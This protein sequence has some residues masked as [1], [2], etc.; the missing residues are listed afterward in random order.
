MFLEDEGIKMY[1]NS[2]VDFLYAEDAKYRWRKL[3]IAETK[4]R[5][6]HDYRI[7]LEVDNILDLMGGMGN[8]SFRKI[9][10]QQFELS[11]SL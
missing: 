6:W 7:D 2:M 10:V 1:D 4:Q 3:D 11:L 8:F 9:S 5:C